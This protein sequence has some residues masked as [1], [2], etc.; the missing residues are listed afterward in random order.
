MEQQELSEKETALSPSDAHNK[1]LRG[2]LN[3]FCSDTHSD[4]HPPP[5]DKDHHHPPPTTTHLHPLPT[6][7]VA[8]EVQGLGG[9][10]ATMAIISAS[11]D[12]E[13]IEENLKLKKLKDTS[14]ILY[15]SSLFCST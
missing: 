2:N 3:I 8:I 10:T 5:T 9:L 13:M 11:L 15:F 7:S 1:Q 12:R 14:D 6:L 4:N